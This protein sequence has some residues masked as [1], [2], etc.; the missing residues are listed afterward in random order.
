MKEIFSKTELAEVF[1]GDI[2]HGASGLCIDSRKAMDGDI[3]FAMKGERVDGHDFVK[4]ALGKGAALAVVEKSL[5]WIA[6]DRQILVESSLKK[7][8]DLARYNVSRIA[9][10]YVSVT[11][12]VGKTTTRSMISHLLSCSNLEVF[13]STKNMNSQIG[14]PL[15][16]AK[17]SR[18]TEFA[19]LE[20]GMSKAGEIKKLVDIAP[21]NV[22]VITAICETHL[23]FFDSVFDIAKAKSEIFEGARPPEIA[24]IPKDSPYTDFL[25][26]R[27][28]KCNVKNIYSFGSSDGADARLLSYDCD[29]DRIYVKAKVLDTPIDYELHCGNISAVYNS[30]AALLAVHLISE[31][32][33]AEMA[34]LL[35]SFMALPG[36]GETILLKNCDIVIIDDSYN[37]SPTSMKS[38]IVSLSKRKYRRKI[39]V[40]GDMLELGPEI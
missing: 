6:E 5:P 8:Q 11:G 40:L 12:S 16:V 14:M 19:I 34:A 3:F 33:L 25:E 1:C 17:M 15:C 20:M 37:A 10:K 22:A 21:P 26:D 38:A 18:H 4:E 28:R 35:P 27:A 31:V 32:P 39:A 29:D 9:A 36:R 30:I 23:E 24:I 2:K 13:T 7:L